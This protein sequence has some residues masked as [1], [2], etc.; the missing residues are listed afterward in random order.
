MM[1]FYC[2]KP[3]NLLYLHVLVKDSCII[4]ILFLCYIQQ[5]LVFVAVQQLLVLV[6]VQQL[7]VFVAVL[8]SS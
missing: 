4:F 7:L 5:L 3:N 2:L 1:I 8:H 6:A